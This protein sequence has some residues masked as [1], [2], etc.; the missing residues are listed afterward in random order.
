MPGQ[1]EADFRCPPLDSRLQVLRLDFVEGEVMA[2]GLTLRFEVFK[3][4]GFTCAYCGRKPPA[5]VLEVDHIVPR[6]AD[7]TD[8]F[9]NLITS[10]FECNR[11]KRDRPLGDIRP[12]PDLEEATE[13]IREREEQ[14]RAYEDVKREE[15]A[16]VNEAIEELFDYWLELGRTSHLPREG[17]LRYWLGIFSS[18][19]IKDAMDIAQQRGRQSYVRYFVGILKNWRDERGGDG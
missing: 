3:R 2:V 1:A 4:D 9:H 5:V 15:R 13:L 18:P 17:A 16:R 6:A 11:G 10:C 7:G 12:H 19:E 14:V 8:E